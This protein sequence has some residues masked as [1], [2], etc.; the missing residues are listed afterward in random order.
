MA[1]VSVCLAALVHTRRPKG[2]SDK[3]LLT[4]WDP[5]QEGSPGRNKIFMVTQNRV[6][7]MSCNTVNVPCFLGLFG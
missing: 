3:Y 6:N 2:V 7:A 4:L 5:G 1:L